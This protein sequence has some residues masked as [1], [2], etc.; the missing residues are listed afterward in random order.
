MT[1]G[2]D[3]HKDTDMTKHLPL[4][5]AALAAALALAAAG[6]A[7][8]IS[9]E[10]A[11]SSGASVVTNYSDLGLL[12]FDI[13]VV[14]FAP[15]ALAFRIDD[16]D[17]S[18]PI[19]FNA[20]VRSFIGAGLPGV[21]LTLSQGSFTTIGSV[22]RFFGGTTDV[23]GTPASVALSF[24]PAEFFDVELGNVYGTTPAAAD[25]K[26]DHTAFLAGDRL[27]L[28]VT[29]VPEPGTMALLASGLGLV[30]WLARRRRAD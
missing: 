20:L 25:W 26:I 15:V 8:A 23:G 1:A 2:T 5:A 27:T 9:F 10:G 4:R 3:T 12:S 19:T 29:P 30:G 22:T 24:S 13:D 16:G 14:D 7:Q 21:T 28:T 11:A 6:S 17:L 18:M